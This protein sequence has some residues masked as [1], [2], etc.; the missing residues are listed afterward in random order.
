LRDIGVKGYLEAN[1]VFPRM[2]AIL[3]IISGAR[4]K[5][6]LLLVDELELIRKFPHARQREQALE[7]LRLLI[8]EAGRNALPGC[9]L[10]FTG[11]DEFFEDQRFGLRSYEAL[12]ERVMTPFTHENFVSMRQPIISLESLDRERLKQVVSKIRDLYAIAYSCAA[13]EFA[14]DESISK[15]I[16]EWTIFGDE[17]IDRK[18]RPILREFIQMLDLCEENKGVNISQFL[19]KSKIEMSSAPIN[20]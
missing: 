11:T 17:N 12:A 5:G 3:E 7:T 1:N 4:Y 13:R 6:L 19:R 16:E 15:L 20:N 10:V 18:P 2:R 8:D 9:L 14:D